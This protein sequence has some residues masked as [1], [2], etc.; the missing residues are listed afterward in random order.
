MTIPFLNTLPRAIT[1]AIVLATVAFGSS[2]HGQVVIFN[3]DFADGDR[4]KTG[5][6]D[7]N[8]WTSNSSAAV[9]IA[10]GALG[11]VTGASGRGLHTVFPTQSLTNDFDSLT[12]VYT[13]TTPATVGGPASAAFRVGLFDT[14]GR[15]D[16]N[17]DVSASTTVPN[18]VYGDTGVMPVNTNTLG[19]PGH[20]LDH[21][22]NEGDGT[23]DLNFRDHVT[24]AASGRL[25]A[26]TESGSFQ[27]FPSGPD[28]GYQFLPNTVYAG[29]FTIT[30][31]S[32]TELGLT[33]TIGSDIYT[34][35]DVAPDSFD[36]GMLAFYV[37]SNVFGS[38]NAAGDPDNGIDFSNVAVVFFSNT[39]FVLGDVDQS[40]TVD[41]LDIGPF[42]NLLSTGG[43]MLQADIDGS[44]AVDFLDI[45][46]F[47]AI[48]SGS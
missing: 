21:D 26:T 42:V 19:L 6:L 35:F 13:F 33:A 28:A 41:F 5:A 7:T 32:A 17:A 16:L 31:L 39:P 15:A 36:F 34:A 24:T 37:N 47:I 4:A 48:L 30:R 20:M 46:P 23:E 44:G 27:S 11:L 9:E 38:S 29:S 3:D 22:I 40:G 14:L 8:W 1:N 18:P 25:M 12:V 43:F 45:G 10:P 2:A